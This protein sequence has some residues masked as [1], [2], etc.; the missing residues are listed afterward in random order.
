MSGPILG[1][2]SRVINNECGG[3]S[4]T[5]PGGGGEN[6]R[7]KAFRFFCNYFDT[8]VGTSQSLS[9]K[10]FSG[11]PTKI[12][13]S[14]DA[15]WTTTWK[16]G[17]CNCTGQS[18]PGPIPYFDEAYYPER[19]TA[20][21]VDNKKKCEDAL[22]DGWQD[23]TTQCK[24]RTE[25]PLKKSK[26][27]SKKSKNTPRKIVQMNEDQ[28]NVVGY[29]GNSGNAVSSIPRLEDINSVYNVLIF[30]FANWQGG[31]I[32]LQ[33]QG[34]YTLNTLK[35][36]ISSWK[37]S[38][39]PWGR[40]KHA[41]ISFGGENGNWP[42][43]DDSTLT[44]RIH[45]FCDQ[46]SFD[47]IDIDLE[48]STVSGVSKNHNAFVT[49]KERFGYIMTAAPEAA[50]YPMNAYQSLL[51]LLTWVHPQFYNNPPNAIIPPFSP[52]D[53]WKY[54]DWQQ[55]GFWAEVMDTTAEY[56]HLSPSQRGV[57]V[58]ASTEAA[59]SYNNWDFDMLAKTMLD[60]GIK[61]VATWALAYDHKDGW[62]LAN[63]VKYLITAT[64]PTPGPT[65]APGTTT[66]NPGKCHWIAIDPRASDAWC[67]IMKENAPPG[68]CKCVFDRARKVYSRLL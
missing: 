8:P 47:G 37:S 38:A 7:I 65:P 34:P 44:Q 13:L 25:K 63:A 51:P 64:W 33:I 45:E 50:Q 12:K 46:N 15:D 41:L 2:T 1:P 28:V 60:H 19:W 27:V 35:G 56:L 57:A 49:L 26:S 18:Y 16:P 32:V 30:T 5:E 55:D 11:F 61:N 59:G 53:S 4:P 48:S 42:N 6:R 29:Y 17:K 36:A 43:L 3:E 10:G 24:G 31:N 68:Y 39:D 21:N 62:K 22:W 66:P 52:A 23:G 67:E 20:M 40:S 54:H 9:C 14:F 58:P